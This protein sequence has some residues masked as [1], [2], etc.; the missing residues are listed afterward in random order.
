MAGGGEEIVYIHGRTVTYL[1]P[2][3]GEP[4]LILVNS[5]REGLR[6]DL[7]A[8]LHQVTTQEQEVVH[9]D[10]RVKT[11]GTYA[12][13]DLTVK[14]IE[15]PEAL[16]GLYHVILE[17]GHGTASV[18]GKGKKI[19][20]DKQDTA[21]SLN[22]IQ[23]LRYTKQRLQHTN[24][25][26]QTSNEGLKSSNEELQSTNEGL[27]STNEESETS[28][29]ELQSLN[30]E[31]LTVNAE[32]QGKI[33]EHSAT[34]DELRNLLD[35]TEIA[36][37]FLDN[38]LNIK[39]FTQ[40]AKQIINLIATDVGRPLTDIASKLPGG[41]LIEQAQHVLRT[42]V[43]YHGEVQTTDGEWFVLRILPY[44]TARNTIHGLVLTFLNITKSKKAE[45]V[46]K[47]AQEFGNMNGIFQPCVGC[48]RKFSLKTARFRIFSSI[49][50][51][52]VSGA[53]LW[54]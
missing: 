26:L 29:E 22:V 34:N 20:T 36:T 21:P 25:E 47:Q 2:A 41:R 37:I 12:L 39:R 38:D 19:G 43:F 14:R 48:S 18:P 5:A 28:K 11:N 4:N 1:E 35:S 33:D 51:L 54:L 40:E 52:R 32:L 17:S 44:R 10:I 13:V 15:G 45:I 27:Q 9:Q 24:E 53:G 6:Y 42:L 16:R 23:E 30:E 46:A 7:A 50:P 8:A 3:F 31:L 49:R